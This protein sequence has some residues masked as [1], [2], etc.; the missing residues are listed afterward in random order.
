MQLPHSWV[1]WSVT[2]PTM[3][4]FRQMKLE[5]KVK[6]TAARRDA[7]LGQGSAQRKITNLACVG[8][9]MREVTRYLARCDAGIC[10]VAYTCKVSWKVLFDGRSRGAGSFDSELVEPQ[11]AG[12]VRVGKAWVFERLLVGHE[13]LKLTS[14]GKFGRLQPDSCLRSIESHRARSMVSRFQIRNC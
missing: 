2:V 3:T 13:T 5:T 9:L 11:R 8:L 4:L 12:S 1:E 14:S 10:W 6:D 7:G